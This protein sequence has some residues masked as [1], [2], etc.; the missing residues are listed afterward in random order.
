MASKIIAQQN[1]AKT[2][3]ALFTDER[4]NIF[5][6]HIDLKEL[7]PEDVLIKVKGECEHPYLCHRMLYTHCLATGVCGSDVHFW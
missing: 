4:H 5:T 1:S 2:N 3:T 6:Q 7:G